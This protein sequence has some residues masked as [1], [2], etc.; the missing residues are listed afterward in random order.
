MSEK[1]KWICTHEK[2]I[3]TSP[4]MEII[5]KNCQ[6][7]EDKRTHQFYLLKSNDWCNI[8]PITE[9]G[10]IV[11]V[12]Q[13][14]IGVDEHTLEIPGGV[15]DSEDSSPAEASIRELTEETG[16]VPLPN[17]QLINLGW[18]YPNPAI[19]N[20]KVHCFIIGPVRKEKAQTLDKGELIETVE[21]PIKTFIHSLI[22]GEIKHAL[23][24]NAFL[25]L[26]LRAPESSSTLHSQLSAFASI[27]LN[28]ES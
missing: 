5:E 20:N 19:Q 25:N 28:L 11:L 22:Q 2:M 24:L 7:S 26:L 14:R 9:D 12:N 21:L 6:S 16:Y 8:I 23:I 18:T 17:A 3:L 10:K 1:N 13:F 4:V 15:I 27:N